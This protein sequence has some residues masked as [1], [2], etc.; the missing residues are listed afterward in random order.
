M[1]EES[2][3]KTEEATPEKLR[4]AREKG[5]VSKSQDMTSAIV[6]AG[7]LI[8][9][10]IAIH[11]M[12]KTLMAL[13]ALSIQQISSSNLQ[14]STQEVL[15]EGGW[16][17]LLVSLPLVATAFFWGLV[18]NYI[19]VGFLLTFEALKPKLEKINPISGFKQLFNA[20]RFVELL[21]QMAKF[22]MVSLLVYGAFKSA[23]PNLVHLQRLELDAALQIVGLVLKDI[24]IKAA[25]LFLIIAVADFFWQR[26]SFMKTMRMTKN[27]MKQEY[28]EAEG[29][30]LLKSERKHLAQELIMHSSQQAV[31]KADAVITN[32][33]HLAVAIR[34]E[35]KEHAAPIVLAKGMGKNAERIRQIAEQYKVPILQNI[36]LAHALN[37]LELEEEIP[38]ELYDAVAEVLNWV[39]Q[40]RKQHV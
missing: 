34:Y 9:L 2:G 11:W 10:A 33:T 13:I 35:A 37:R 19:Q 3:E 14:N 24:F 28:K 36:P 40:M 23:V 32:P 17:W 30:P 26:H 20:K 38:E 4:K 7:S 8:T 25:I 18:G 5:Q 16:I 27:E 6:F 15:K 1:T 31:K 29:D 12:G 39:Y 21:K 22:T